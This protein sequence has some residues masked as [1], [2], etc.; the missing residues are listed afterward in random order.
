MFAQSDTFGVSLAGSATDQGAEFTL[1]Y[2][3]RNFA[4]V[5]VVVEEDDGTFKQIEATGVDVDGKTEVKEAFS[6]LGQF[7]ANTV[8][9]A[10]VNLKTTVGLGKF[11]ATG[12]A[13]RQL[14]AGFAAKMASNS[15]GNGGD[16]PATP[17]A[18]TPN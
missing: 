9:E 5:P 16:Q 8:A 7:E 10:Q 15:G 1:G 6:V 2:R 3:G 11:F 18:T 14:A 12:L 13:A 4:I 17:A